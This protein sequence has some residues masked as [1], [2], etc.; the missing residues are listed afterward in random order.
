MELQ[1]SLTIN[2]KQYQKGDF[3]A[4][5]KVYPLFLL[6]MAMFGA[7]GFFMA[8]AG[9]GPPL[10]FLYLHGGLACLVYLI[11]YVTIFGVDQDIRKFASDPG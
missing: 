7:S 5:Y 8:Y 6:H 1:G 4:W 2:G 11:F 9:E 10:P 3:V